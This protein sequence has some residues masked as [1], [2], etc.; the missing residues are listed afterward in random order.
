M[1]APLVEGGGGGATNGGVGCGDD[2]TGA[3]H[4]AGRDAVPTSASCPKSLPDACD[5]SP[6]FWSGLSYRVS[7]PCEQVERALD[8]RDWRFVLTRSAHAHISAPCAHTTEPRAIVDGATAPAQEPKREPSAVEASEQM[9]GA[10]F[11]VTDGEVTVGPVDGDLLTRGIQ[12]GKVPL[13]AM[14][15]CQGW[16]RWQSVDVYAREA[17]LIAHTEKAKQHAKLAR[18]SDLAALQLPPIDPQ[19]QSLAEAA[20]LNEAACMALSM[21]AAVSGAECGWVH[22]QSRE[23][24]GAMIT[25]DGIGPRSAF[26][27]GRTIDPS[28]Q[29]LRVA[30]EGRTVLSEP[31][32]GVVGSAIAARI[33]ATGLAPNSVLMAPVV[34]AG[35]LVAMI[36]LG[37]ATRTTGFT[38]REA[39]VVEQIA[40]DL[41]GLARKRN[42]VSS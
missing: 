15:W 24:A 42:W 30:R 34:C 17:G 23:A 4:R 36:E 35:T 21:A 3:K 26:G 9:Q 18:V 6:W 19:K 31:I 32:P 16:D 1:A 25:L 8:T 12:A 7:C 14:V 11:F 10:R 27:I 5:T 37:V 2:C 38:A 22:V 28:D 40:R 13:E 29:A 39:A 33:L 41:A 20:S